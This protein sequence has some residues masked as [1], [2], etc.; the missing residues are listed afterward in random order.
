MSYFIL[1]KS[2]LLKISFQFVRFSTLSY[3]LLSTFF[4]LL[5]PSRLFVIKI[6]SDVRDSDVRDIFNDPT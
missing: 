2:V 5:K 1:P 4:K 6:G 3:I